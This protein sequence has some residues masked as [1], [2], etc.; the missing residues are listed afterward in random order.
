MWQS[1]STSDTSCDVN[2]KMGRE[3]TNKKRVIVTTKLE[4][5]NNPAPSFTETH[6]SKNVNFIYD[7]KQE[8]KD[9]SI[10]GL[11]VKEGMEKICD[12]A[13][14]NYSYLTSIKLPKSIQ[15][16]GVEAFT[17]C[18]SLKTIDISSAKVIRSK[19]F[20]YCTNLKSIHLPQSL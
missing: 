2:H 19:A 9:K 10:K 8:E 12:R 1:N 15:E 11:T 20:E 13:F 6:N 14:F 3:T 16:I 7:G 17:A 4:K 18:Y 5:E